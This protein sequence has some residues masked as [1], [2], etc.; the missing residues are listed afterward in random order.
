LRA[1]DVCLRT[2]LQQTSIDI[3][4]EAADSKST[5]PNTLSKQATINLDRSWSIARS[6]AA[7]GVGDPPHHHQ[8][9]PT[10]MGDSDQQ[11]HV[12]RVLRARNAFEVLE[13]AICEH[14]EGAVK[15]CVLV[16]TLLWHTL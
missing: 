4:R 14:E 13:L 6:V 16:C 12:A 9:T 15:R 7:N 3:D 11:Q 8:T 2:K 1:L 10:A 5:N